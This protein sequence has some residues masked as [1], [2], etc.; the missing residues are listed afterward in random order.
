MS[1]H[2][3]SDRPGLPWQVKWREGGRQRSE[4][5]KTERHAR[6]HD[7]RMQVRAEQGAHAPPEPS[8]M[9]LTDW[10]TRWVETF[11]PQWAASTHRTRGNTID[12]HLIP[13]A[14]D[15]RLKDLGRA[16]IRDVRAAMLT[17]GRTPDTVN[18]TIRVLSAALGA[19]VDEGLLPGN[20]CRGLKPLPVPPV[21]R[22]PIDA[23]TL[24]AVT[25]LMAT[26]RD[27]AVV[28][29]LFHAG[30]RPGELRGLRWRDIQPAGLVVRR[31]MG[32]A[33]VKE[34]KTGVARV[35]PVREAVRL[36]VDELRENGRVEPDGLVIRGDH[37]GPLD[38]GN[39]T[40]RVWKPAVAAVTRARIVPYQGR[41][42][43]ASALIHDGHSPVEVA[44]WMGHADV[45]T[46]LRHYA[47]LM[48]Q[49]G[50]GVRHEVPRPGG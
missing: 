38:W 49:P 3:R 44:A 39:W 23:V 35:V 7:A 14:G 36:A 13:H 25:A 9:V 32:D 4:S 45:G 18:H 19:A 47:H 2:F 24:D 10:I 46:T 41:H 33:G 17:A 37:G 15:I 5:F 6:R 8:R 21:D 31:A 1:V 30:L 16:R 11:G 22:D 29:F 27:R 50:R 26:P 28:A 48:P 40:A 42:T 43:Y 34:T 20:P 12:A